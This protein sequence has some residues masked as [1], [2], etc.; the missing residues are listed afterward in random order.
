MF[1]YLQGT[2]DVSLYIK[3]NYTLSSTCFSTVSLPLSGFSYADWAASFD[4]RKSIGGYCVY[5]G[6]SLIS[7]SS[8]KQNVV[9][10]SSTKS[11]H[12]ALSNMETEIVSIR[13]LLNELKFPSFAAAIMWCDNL[14][15]GSLACNSG[16]HVG[17]K[18]IELDVHFIRDKIQA[19]EIEVKYVLSLD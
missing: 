4:D 14:S 6:E 10:R 11:E 9:A 18:H 16:F 12:R 15:A 1:R 13:F 17:T 3:G 7:W 2:I 19:K 8:H 5:L